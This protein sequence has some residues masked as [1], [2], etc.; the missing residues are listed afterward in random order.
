MKILF[1]LIYFCLQTICLQAG[2]ADVVKVIVENLGR[3]QYRFDVT[4]LHQDEGWEHYANKW[5]IVS[6]D[7]AVLG[8]RVL[9]HPHVNEQP[10]TRSLSDLEIS[11]E[12]KKV[13]V[14]AHDSQHEYG[15]IVLTVDLPE[16]GLTA[17]ASSDRVPEKSGQ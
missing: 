14:R 9:Y 2:E 1:F 15:G 8:T 12:I 4:V 16:E 10:F 17:A 13:V 7:G 5:E 11:P 6:L 3:D